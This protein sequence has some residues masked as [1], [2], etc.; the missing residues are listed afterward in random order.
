MSVTFTGTGTEQ[1][2]YLIETAEQ[3][4]VAFE[5]QNS[6]RHH[7]DV[8]QNIDMQNTTLGGYVDIYA[9]ID[10]KGHVISN[11]VFA[12][13][14]LWQ[15]IR[16]TIKNLHMEWY[17]NTASRKLSYLC[18]STVSGNSIENVR[19]DIYGETT[20]WSTFYT[21]IEN[22]VTC[23]VT[24]NTN[25]NGR[26]TYVFNSSRNVKTDITGNDTLVS[27]YP[28]IDEAIW[29]VTGGS[30]PVLIPQAGDYSQY[31]H[32]MG[33]TLVDGVGRPRKVRAVTADRHSLIAELVSGEDGTYDLGT[34]PYTHGILVYTFDDYGVDIQ[35]GTV[36][37]VDDIVHPRQGNGYRYV[38]V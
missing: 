37:A 33:K 13:P 11:A 5:D 3:F 1:S 10:G 9:N 15:R 36:Y 16:G 32:V 7:Y 14:Y 4:K 23:I 6:A 17:P 12:S 20:N 31:T 22:A 29:N 28:N 38:C 19:M 24:E 8:I 2:P 18:S 34:T 27:S 21:N 25:A 26:R 30:V 35:P